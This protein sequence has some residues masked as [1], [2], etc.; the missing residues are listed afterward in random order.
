MSKFKIDRLLSGREHWAIAG[1]EF[2]VDKCKRGP[3]RCIGYA[4]VTAELP[5]EGFDDP[6]TQSRLGC[7]CWHADAVILY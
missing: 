7:I 1:S 5:G 4:D 6:G 3:R 2:V